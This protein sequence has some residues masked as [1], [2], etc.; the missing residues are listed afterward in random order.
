MSRVH[1]RAYQLLA[2]RMRLRPGARM[3]LYAIGVLLVASG[4]GW[5]V[6]H[7]EGDWM[8]E[9]RNDLRRVALEAWAM[10]VHGAAAFVAL[11]AIGSMLTHHVRRGWALDRNRDSGTVVTAVLAVLT[12]TGY[13]LYYAV[14]EETRPPVS[15]VHWVLGLALAPLFALHIAIGR[16]SR[17]RQRW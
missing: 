8:P 10:R 3:T 15:L 9:W 14:S 6:V 11:I 1:D 7:Y 17:E 4:A 16:R 5:I 13:A 2:E 12:L